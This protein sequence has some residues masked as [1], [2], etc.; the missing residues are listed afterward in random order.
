MVKTRALLTEF[1][2]AWLKLPPPPTNNDKD[3]VIVKVPCTYWND[4]KKYPCII[5]TLV[6]S[7]DSKKYYPWSEAEN[8]ELFF[9]RK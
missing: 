4:S 9:S 6:L 1:C 3:Q 8:K 7:K 2:V 5:V